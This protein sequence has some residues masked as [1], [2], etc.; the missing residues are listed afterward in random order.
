MRISPSTPGIPYRE[1]IG[2]AGL[3]IRIEPATKTPNTSSRSGPK[4]I[5]IP[6]GVDVGT[7]I[8]AM[9]HHP[10]H[11]PDS[12]AFRPERWLR[13]VLAFGEQSA[14]LD[15]SSVTA[16][17]VNNLRVEHLLEW[18]YAAYTPFSLGPRGCPGRMLALME[19]ALVIARTLWE[20]DLRVAP[21]LQNGR[22]GGGVSGLTGGRGRLEEYQ[23]WSH[24]TAASE[25]P[26]LQ[27]RKPM[28]VEERHDQG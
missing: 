7:C 14:P 6:A 26:V 28:K 9:H 4:T 11:F 20:L 13:E 16:P 19:I 10:A 18:Q 22:L 27:F 1:V 24:V 8:Y 15:A 23:L 17:E 25:G 3:D 12:F 21:D 2:P 5:H